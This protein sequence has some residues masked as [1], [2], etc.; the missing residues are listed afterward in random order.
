[1]EKKNGKFIQYSSY[2]KVKI[3]GEYKNG[4]EWNVKSYD[5]D[6]SMIYE[7]KN[8]EGYVKKYIDIK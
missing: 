3:E 1:M 8:G 2:R 7:L 4:K 5:E 6:N